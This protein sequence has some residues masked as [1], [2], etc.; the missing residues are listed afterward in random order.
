MNFKNLLK[1]V[2]TLG[3]FAVLA[4]GCSDEP[5]VVDPD[6]GNVVPASGFYLLNQ[7][8]MGQNQAS[9]DYYDFSTGTLTLD[10]YRKQN[11]TVAMALGDVGNQIAIYDNK[12]WAVINCSNKVEVMD[13][14]CVRIGQIEIPNCRYIAFFGDYAYVTSYAGPVDYQT[15]PTQLGYVAKINV[16]TL[17]EEGRCTVG[18]QPDGIA[19]SNG[20]IYVANSYGYT[21]QNEPGKMSV[22]DVASFK[23]DKEVEVGINLNQVAADA[24]GKIWITSRGN[25]YNVASA[26]H[27]YDPAQ[28]KVVADYDVPNSYITIEGHTLYVIGVNWS[29]DTYE[30]QI[31]YAEINTLE[32]KV[33][34][35]RWEGSSEYSEME[36][37]YCLAVAPANGDIFVTDAG[38][39]INPGYIYCFSSD[40]TFKWRKRTGVSPASIAFLK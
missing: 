13:M 23:V 14:K 21:G 30:K 39:F 11:P 3:I 40:K 4:T 27:C 15:G 32:G 18:Y 37:P 28:D 8:N 20:K 29:L 5:E 9:I 24:E 2:L 1:S 7:G 34:T 35:R 22:I 10:F 19:I 16:K 12:V 26:I 38:D 25:Y 33:T 17:K 31:S 6:E 36:Y